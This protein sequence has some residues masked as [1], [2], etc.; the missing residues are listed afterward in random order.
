[1]AA[2][3][4]AL[5]FAGPLSLVSWQ[6]TRFRKTRK[7]SKSNR[8]LGKPYS[9]TFIPYANHPPSVY[10]VGPRLCPRYDPEPDE[11]PRGQPGEKDSDWLP[12]LHG[13]R[14]VLA[15]R[16][17]NAENPWRIG[18][19]GSRVLGLRRHPERLPAILSDTIAQ[20]A[21]RTWPQ[22]LRHA[23]GVEGA[24]DGESG[25]HPRKQPHPRQRVS[26]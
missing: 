8:Q 15:Q 11:R 1:M 20:A 19:P 14:R 17:R 13:A 3:Q 24:G 12:A 16:A 10:Q 26:Q 9:Q 22:V 5:R 2:V 25:S 21:R 6:P 23:P 7:P 4:S 18:L